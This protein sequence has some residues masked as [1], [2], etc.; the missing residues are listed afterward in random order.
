[1]AVKKNKDYLCFSFEDFLE[2]D[3]FISTHLH[4]TRESELF[5]ADFRNGEAPN[6]AVFRKAVRCLE[7]LNRDLAAEDD[8]AQIWNRIR[9]SN[10]RHRLKS[11]IIYLAVSVAACAAFFIFLH[12]QSFESSPDINTSALKSFVETYPTGNITEARLILAGGDTVNL[13]G[14]ES[15]I[16]YGHESIGV[17]SEGADE[18]SKGKSPGYDRLLI[19]NGQ[20][21]LL[22]LSDGTRVWVN[23]GTRLVYPSEFAADRRE[24]YV[25]GEIFIDVFSDPSRPFTV[26]TRDFDMEVLGTEF[27]VLAYGSDKLK[28][29][30]LKSGSLKISGA[31][32]VETVLSPDEMYELADGRQTVAKVDADVYTSWVNGIYI[33]HD[34]KPRDFFMW[35]SRYYGVEITAGDDVAGLR[36]NG[37]LELK[38]DLQ[39]VLRIIEYIA[40]VGFTGE[41]GNYTAVRRQP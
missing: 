7:D 13:T 6:A 4:P 35:L 15:V 34:E 22:N 19:P 25:D 21:T 23:S 9:K 11:G 27:G 16:A 38:N 39:G 2:D 5:W 1:M 40:P 3:Y 24:I 14:R 41:D 29:V 37:K 10:N 12:R 31:G 36:F 8:L 26:L 32:A 20:R 18:I 33:C 28:R 30:V 17:R